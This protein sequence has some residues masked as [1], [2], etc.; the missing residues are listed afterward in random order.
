M[1]K[2]SSINITL[3]ILFICF[4]VETP[5]YSNKRQLKAKLTSEFNEL[6]INTN[7]EVFLQSG[8]DYKVFVEASTFQ[9]SCL[10]IINQ[11]NSLTIEWKPITRALL[12]LHDYWVDSEKIAIYITVPRLEKAH[13]HPEASLIANAN[14]E[15]LKVEHKGA[16]YSNLLTASLFNF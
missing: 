15:K 14:F 11:D 9:L 2:I 5:F 8:D 13:L 1:S 4:L 16:S 10:E 6:K 3:V 7:S 12:W